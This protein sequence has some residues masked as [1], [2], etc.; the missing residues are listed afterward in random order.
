LVIANGNIP[1]RIYTKET[2]DDTAMSI[3]YAVGIWERDPATIHALRHELGRK[4]EGTRS[5]FPFTSLTPTR[6]LA[7]Y[8]IDF[9]DTSSGSVAAVSFGGH[10]WQAIGW[11]P[12]NVTKGYGWNSLY[13]GVP[14]TIQ[15]GNPILRCINAGS[16]NIIQSTICYDDYNHPDEF[17]YALPQGVYNVTVG[18]GWP[19]ACRGD[20]EFISI[21]NVVLRNQTCS[22]CCQDV[23]EYWGKVQVNPGANGAGIVMTFG[24]TNGYSI[25]S[26]MKI[27]TSA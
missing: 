26:Y 18:I 21:N 24:D 11:E 7:N 25:L 19:G 15:T 3:G 2:V 6:A 22:P 23:R 10:T 16:G 27:E 17:H 9:Q 13:M 1:G 12:Y 5:D 8:Y 4:I 20:S 14:N